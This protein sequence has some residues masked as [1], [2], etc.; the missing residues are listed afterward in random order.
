MSTDN[1]SVLDFS[2]TYCGEVLKVLVF[3]TPCVISTMTYTWACLKPA[4]IL[5]LKT[6]PAHIPINI[7]LLKRYLYISKWV[8]GYECMCLF[9]FSRNPMFWWT[10]TH[11]HQYSCGILAYPSRMHVAENIH[12]NTHLELNH[13]RKAVQKVQRDQ[14]PA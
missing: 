6:Y 1:L 11:E 10:E 4:W 5:A 12:P 3:C 9:I 13:G 7:T 14:A 8:S 2:T